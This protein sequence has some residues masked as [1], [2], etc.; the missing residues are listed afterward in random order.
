MKWLHLHHV[1]V[2]TKTISQFPLANGF[3]LN[4]RNLSML[5]IRKEKLPY[6]PGLTDRAIDVKWLE[7]FKRYWKMTKIALVLLLFTAV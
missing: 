2:W 1:F 4:Y 6:F 5:L 7:R 3:F